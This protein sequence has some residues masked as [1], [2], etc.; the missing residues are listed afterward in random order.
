MERRENANRGEGDGTVLLGGDVAKEADEG[1][2]V[3]PVCVNTNEKT[4]QNSFFTDPECLFS[5]PSIVNI[6]RF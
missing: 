6:F 1:E 3:A 4:V 2:N 5:A